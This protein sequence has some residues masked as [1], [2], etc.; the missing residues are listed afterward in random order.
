[1]REIYR[2]YLN[3]GC[4]SKLKTYLE[5]NGIRSKER[6]G[7]TGRETGGAAYSRGALYNVLRNRT[8]LGEIEH[9]G[10]VYPGEHEAIVPRE[11]WERVQARLQ[12]NDHAH[13]DRSRAAMP[14][15]LVGLIHDERGNRFTPAHA[16]K[17]GKRYRYYVSQAAIKNPGSGHRGP[18]RIPAGEIERLVCSRLRSFLGSPQELANTLSLQRKNVAATHRVLAAAQK[19]SQLVAPAVAA[20]TRPFVRSIISRIVVHTAIVVVLLDRQS[21]QSALIGSAGSPTLT[22]ADRCNGHLT[23]RIKA[24]LQ[25]YGGE[26]RLVL[27]AKSGGETPSTPC[28]P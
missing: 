15:L 5:R 26:V 6:L 11:L 20:E 7:P 10:Q 22:M 1:V 3:L 19:W 4:V 24:R 2:Q 13:K 23:L 25:R 18:I 21:L 27:P 14:S 28:L 12:A 8:Y 17:N 16:V 9:R